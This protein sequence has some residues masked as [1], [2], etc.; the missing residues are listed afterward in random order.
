M[1]CGMSPQSPTAAVGLSRSGNNSVLL[2]AS[3]N[4]PNGPFR[5]TEQIDPPT[6]PALQPEPPFDVIAQRTR[7]RPDKATTYYVVIDPIDVTTEIFK[8]TVKSVFAALAS[9]EG[10]PQFSAH[11]WDSLTAAQTEVS[12]K[13]QP[14]LF[15]DDQIAAKE[16]ANET[17][18]VASYVGG[19]VYPGESPSF[20]ILWFPHSSIDNLAV[21]QW[22]SAEVWEAR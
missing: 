12:Y 2:P 6:S 21:G 17:H 8:D 13:S 15:S 18:F 4:P 1:G 5:A 19:L 9:V 22:V 14:D 16:T 7:D 20:V 10:G 11:V 3:I